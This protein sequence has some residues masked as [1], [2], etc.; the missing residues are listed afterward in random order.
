MNASE[1]IVLSALLV[2]ARIVHSVE[3][4]ASSNRHVADTSR[5]GRGLLSKSRETAQSEFLSIFLLNK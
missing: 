5:Y 2:I 1:L 4:L 3:P